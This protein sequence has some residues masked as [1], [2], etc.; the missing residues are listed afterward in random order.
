MLRRWVPLVGINAVPLGGVFLAG[1]SPAT[2]LS[3]YWWE[4]LVGA[5]LVALRIAIHRALTRKRGHRRLQ[6]GVRQDV[7]DEERKPRRRASPSDHGEPGSFLAEFLLVAGAGTAVHGLLLWGLLR[8]FLET[9]PEGEQLRLGVLIVSLLQIGGFLLDL[10]GIRQRP[11]AWIRD[12]AQVNAARVSLLHLTLLA[13]FWFA[14]GPSGL[15]GVLGPFVVLKALAELG[16]ALSHAGF[17]ADPEESPPWLTAAMN[18]LRPGGGDFAAHWRERKERE[19]RLREQ[20]EESLDRDRNHVAV[21]R[22]RR[23]VHQKR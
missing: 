12:L 5:A 6:L 11:F 14:T 3:L 7:G 23:G 13:G 18:R 9:G 19:R 20:D 8:G 2:A 10:V 1:W 16:G 4:N 21:S 15:S 22:S 17:D